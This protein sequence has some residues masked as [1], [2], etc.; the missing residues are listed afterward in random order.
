MS[1]IF[2]GK[3]VR[4]LAIRATLLDECG[5]PVNVATTTKTQI[6]TSA[7]ISASFS[8][9]VEEGEKIRQKLAN[10][11]FCINDSE[12]CDKLMGLEATIM[13]CAL[14]PHFFEL[15]IGA[16]QLTDN[17]KNVVG[18]VLPGIPG[19][20]HCPNHVMLEIWAENSDKKCDADGRV[21][22]YIRYILPDSF[23][24][25]WSSDAT[26]ESGNAVEWEIKGY[27]EGNPYF[28]SP[29]PNDP[30][31]TEANIKAIQSAGPLAW[32]CS[33]TLPAIVNDN[34]V[35]P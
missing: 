29:V 28:Q 16:T 22:R 5:K 21:C 19:G 2:M 17:D 32:V 10:G 31:L 25:M 3:S 6:S 13:L 26:I 34:W 18:G 12:D 1:S 27:V 7:F 33:N 4:G 14:P 35:N 23:R 24:W 11:S 9:D 15:L 20:D 8:P 30:D